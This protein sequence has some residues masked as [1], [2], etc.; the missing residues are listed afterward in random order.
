MLQEYT[1]ISVYNLS[2]EYIQAFGVRT[3]AFEKKLVNVQ[4]HLGDFADAFIQN[5]HSF[6]HSQTDGESTTQ[7]HIQLVRRS[8]GEASC[9]GT[10]R[11][12]ARKS[13][14]SP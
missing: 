5:D 13:R 8:Q 12:S 4:L 3:L 7:G 14:G 10:P 6:T 1:Q 11:H 2:K 9:S